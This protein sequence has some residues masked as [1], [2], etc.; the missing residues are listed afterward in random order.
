[1][2]TIPFSYVK[3]E[4]HRA[5]DPSVLEQLARNHISSGQPVRLSDSGS[6]SVQ[7]KSNE[8]AEADTQIN[9]VKL[10]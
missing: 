5:A 8:Y 3:T 7:H 1:M 10:Y 2:S 4:D 9:Q 6:V